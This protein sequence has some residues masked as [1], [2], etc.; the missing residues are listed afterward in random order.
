MQ[1]PS[2]GRWV[3]AE[4]GRGRGL[5][6]IVLDTMVFIDLHAGG[7]LGNLHYLRDIY[8]FRTTN[9]IEEELKSINP[10]FMR[11][12]GVKF[13]ELPG[14]EMQKVEE[15]VQKYPRASPQDHSTMVLANRLGCMLITRD[16]SLIETKH[17]EYPAMQHDHT[18]WLIEQMVEREVLSLKEAR[19]AFDAI[20]KNNSRFRDGIGLDRLKSLFQMR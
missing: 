6:D 4:T 16:G 17:I 15:L 2:G 5:Q 9:F 1:A 7:I 19:S 3:Y 11:Q 13:E 20:I 10:D 8:S 12:L 18:V 14:T